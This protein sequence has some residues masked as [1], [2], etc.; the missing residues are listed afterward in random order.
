MQG[1]LVENSQGEK[2]LT[3]PLDFPAGV[4]V[5]VACEKVAQAIDIAKHSE[6]HADVIE[7]RSGMGRRIV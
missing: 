3:V 5:S 7:I 2:Q 6:S 4:C 1:G